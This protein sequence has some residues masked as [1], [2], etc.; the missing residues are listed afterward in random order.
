MKL[1]APVE[2]PHK[3]FCT[4][5]CHTSFYLKRCLVCEQPITKTSSRQEICRKSSCRNAF[6]GN[7]N[8]FRYRT[9]A[10]G[11]DASRN[12][13]KP[14][15][16]TSPRRRSTASFANAPLNILGGGSWR[17]PNTPRLDANTLENIRHREIAA[18]ERV[19]EETGTNEKS[20]PGV[21]APRAPELNVMVRPVKKKGN[22]QCQIQ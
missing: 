21:R 15:V 3:A 4:P 9:L 7:R 17:W 2:N 22:L 20:A 6:R 16:K 19:A 10:S 14:G 18:I 11:A 8:R 13:I 1:K 12:P 5:G